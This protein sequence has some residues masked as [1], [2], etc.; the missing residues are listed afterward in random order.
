MDTRRYAMAI[1]LAAVLAAVS[2]GLVGGRAAL[3]GAL[4]AALVFAASL[5]ITARN[6][7]RPQLPAL[8]PLF[9]LLKM[10]LIGFCLWGLVQNYPPVA[11]VV[12]GLS[13]LIGLVATAL[14]PSGARPTRPGPEP[15]VAEA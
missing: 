7:S 12:G 3:M 11:V 8:G 14:A 9:F 5:G 15:A 13:P 2:A 6:L 1:A 10:P 4:G